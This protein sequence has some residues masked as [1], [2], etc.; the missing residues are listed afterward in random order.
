MGIRSHVLSSIF[1]N[2]TLI[3]LWNS[4]AIGM[5]DKDHMFR[6]GGNRLVCTAY[7]ISALASSEITGKFT[8]HT[9]IHF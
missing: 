6:D 9:E 4:L 2:T 1:T 7:G 8:F 3:S 5:P